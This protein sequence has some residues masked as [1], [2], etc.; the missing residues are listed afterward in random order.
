MNQL[1]RPSGNQIIVGS[2]QFRNVVVV[3]NLDAQGGI[4]D[5]GT[6]TCHAMTYLQAG[7]NIAK[8]CSC[9]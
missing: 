3:P 7:C 2:K 4:I 8:W 5:D 9:L 1:V 6:L